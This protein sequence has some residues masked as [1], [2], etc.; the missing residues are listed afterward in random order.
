MSHSID[1]H[2]KDHKEA[3]DYAIGTVYLDGK[4]LEIPENKVVADIALIQKLDAA[5]EHEIVVE[6]I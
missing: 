4:Q 3:G 5:S 6:L 2:N 1:H